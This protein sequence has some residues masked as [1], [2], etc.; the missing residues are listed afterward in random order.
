MILNACFLAIGC[1]AGL[2]ELALG[3]RLGCREGGRTAEMREGLGARLVVQAGFWEHL[4]ERH[5]KFM[6]KVVP[7]CL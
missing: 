4:P 1:G 3:K 5:L 7:Q 2:R 6:N